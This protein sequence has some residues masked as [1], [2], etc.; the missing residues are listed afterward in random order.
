MKVKLLVKFYQDFGR[1]GELEGLFVVNKDQYDRAIADQPSAYFGEALGKH[2]EVECVLSEENLTIQ[3]ADQPFITRLVRIAGSETISGYNP[4][5]YL[6]D[7][8]NKN[9]D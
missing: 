5:D 8:D 4:F 6:A 3:D 9:G 1:S 2:S 7:D